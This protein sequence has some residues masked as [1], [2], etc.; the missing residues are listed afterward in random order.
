MAITMK[1]II[2]ESALTPE[3]PNEFRIT[4]ELI[5]NK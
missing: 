1:P 3:A 5:S 4:L 2:L